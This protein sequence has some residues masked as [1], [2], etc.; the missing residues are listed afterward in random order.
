MLKCRVPA[1]IIAVAIGGAGLAA[2]GSS[3]SSS[4][5]AGVR[6]TASASATP[7]SSA[8]SASPTAS[9]AR[10]HSAAVEISSAAPDPATSAAPDPATSTATHAA[11]IPAKVPSSSTGSGTHYFT[12]PGIA[13][14]NIVTGHG[15][16]TRVG[17]GSVKV[18]ICAQQTGAAFSVGTEAIA[19]NSSGGSQNLGAVV[20]TGPGAPTCVSGTIPFYTAHL[21]VHA[22]IGGD[23]GTITATGPV[24]TLY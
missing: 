14:D 5:A 17:T 11:A 16:Y 2:C 18:S 20:L 13:G 15:S 4:A 24:L 8:S 23:K 6:A 7:A 19:Y 3:A 21:K 12:V 9:P 22:F 10:T 1:V